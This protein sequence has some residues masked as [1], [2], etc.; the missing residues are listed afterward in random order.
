MVKVDQ[1]LVRRVAD[2]AM[3]ALDDAA[4]A[5]MEQSLARI[6]A[7]CEGLQAVDTEGVEPLYFLTQRRE[8]W[9]EDVPAEPLPKEKAVM[10]APD[11]DGDYFRVP[12]TVIKE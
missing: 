5:E 3:L 12:K 10:N 4:V 6:L 2:L 9:R 8:V 1:A 7:L 11:T